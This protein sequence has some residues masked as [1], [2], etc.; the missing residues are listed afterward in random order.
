[1]LDG[2][3]PIADDWYTKASLLPDA[4]NIKER[5]LLS[6]FLHISIPTS[7][8]VH[9]RNMFPKLLVHLKGNTP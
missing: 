3:V 8:G 2:L 4:E 6:R 9:P 7:E 5:I 1:M